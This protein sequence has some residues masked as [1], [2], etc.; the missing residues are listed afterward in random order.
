MK[1]VD[2]KRLQAIGD[3]WIEAGTSPVL[4]VLSAVIHGEFNCLLNPAHPDF[5]KLKFSDPESFSFDK[6]LGWRTRPYGL[7]KPERS[8]LVLSGLEG[9]FRS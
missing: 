8:E 9:D 4:G 6:R 7:T 2:P 5:G 1:L 3:E